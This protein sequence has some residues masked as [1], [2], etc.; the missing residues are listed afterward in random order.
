MTITTWTKCADQLPD[1]GI[2]VLLAFADGEVWAGFL[3]GDD[4]R[5]ADLKECGVTHWAHLP[6]HPDDELA[7]MPC[8]GNGDE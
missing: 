8:I 7:K 3:D 1:D 5:C 2:V 6:P 4:W